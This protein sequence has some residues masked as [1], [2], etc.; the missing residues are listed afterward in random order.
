MDIIIKSENLDKIQTVIDEVQKRSRT[1][2]IRVSDVVNAVRYVEE[3]LFL[4]PKKYWNGTTATVNENAQKFAM[5]YYGTPEAT[6]FKLEYRSNA[7]HLVDVYR[8]ICTDK[9]IRCTYTEE[10]K[11]IAKNSIVEYME[12]GH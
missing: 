3:R 7:W 6:I 1:R 9:R 8:G 11:S 5:A 10:I 4:V 2:K 12:N